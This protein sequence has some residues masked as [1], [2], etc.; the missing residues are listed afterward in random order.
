MTALELARGALAGL[1]RSR[2]RIDDLNVYPVPDGDTGTNLTMTGRAIVESLEQSTATE[3]AA[4]A[5]ELTRAALMGARGNSGVILSQIVR[6]FAE[7]VGD[8]PQLDVATVV[9]AFRSAS[10]AAYRAVRKPV[11]GTMLTVIRELAEAAEGSSAGEVEELL[12]ELV[13]AGE[14]SV[15]GT[16]EKLDVLRHAGVVDAGGAGLVEILRGI[17]AAATM[18]TSCQPCGMCTGAIERSGLG[19]VVFA[20]STEQL[21]TLKPPGGPPPVRHEGPALFDEARIPLEGYYQ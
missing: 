16:T 20:L 4:I 12:V 21:A 8:R 2:R 11:E 15:R 17:A 1:E 13:R 5:K 9:E 14:E 7:V 10:D 6:G 3:R 18:Y 19:R